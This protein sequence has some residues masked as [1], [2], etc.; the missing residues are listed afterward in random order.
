MSLSLI[1]AVLALVEG[2]QMVLDRKVTRLKTK[3]EAND[4]LPDGGQPRPRWRRVLDWL[5]AMAAPR[6]AASDRDGVLSNRR[7]VHAVLLGAGGGVVAAVVGQPAL[8]GPVIGA[9][10]GLEVGGRLSAK[11]RK[12]L[13]REPWYGIGAALLAYAATWLAGVSVL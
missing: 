10:L 12:E 6:E 2:H 7:E 11:V 1:L 9:S 3:L 5:R 13:R 8:L 4:V